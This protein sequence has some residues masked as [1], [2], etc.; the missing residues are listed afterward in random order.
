MIA[1]NNVFCWNFRI[2]MRD[3]V[4]ASARSLF[5]RVSMKRRS[6]LEHD[7]LADCK[8]RSAFRLF[9]ST[10]NHYDYCCCCFILR[11]LYLFV[12]FYRFFFG[13]VYD[14]FTQIIFWTFR[15]CLRVHDRRILLRFALLCRL[16]WFYWS[17]VESERAT[18]KDKCWGSQR[19]LCCIEFYAFK[20][21]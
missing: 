1:A 9:F 3:Y 12:Y 4:S 17:F 13:Y 2:T 14:E 11:P 7:H 21:C 19:Y 18:R 16:L 15:V 20:L 10:H 5:E 6:Q 8:L